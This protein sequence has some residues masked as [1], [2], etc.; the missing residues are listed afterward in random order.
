MIDKTKLKE[1]LKEEEIISFRTIEKMIEYLKVD[2][3]IH[4]D[5]EKEYFDYLC[6]YYFKHNKKH[7]IIL[8]DDALDVY[9]DLEKEKEKWIEKKN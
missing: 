6:Y 8:F 7:Y 4:L 3:F 2:C 5:S 1:Y 9:N